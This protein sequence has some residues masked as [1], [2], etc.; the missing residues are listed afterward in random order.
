MSEKI[1]DLIETEFNYWNKHRTF[2]P[3]TLNLLFD[4]LELTKEL[5]EF[6]SLID[7]NYKHMGLLEQFIDESLL[8]WRKRL[9]NKDNKLISQLFLKLNKDIANILFGLPTDKYIILSHILYSSNINFDFKL[10]FQE[11]ISPQ[12]F[13]NQD[14]DLPDIM[15]KSLPDLLATLKSYKFYNDEFGLFEN[16]APMLF[17]MPEELQIEMIYQL[18]LAKKHN[19]HEAAVLFLLHPE[20]I[21]RQLVIKLF[22][23]SDTKLFNSSD[24]RRLIVMRNWITLD[25]KKD[26]DSLIYNLRK[27]KLAPAPYPISKILRVV[28]TNADGAGAMMAFI[29][30][31]QN[32]KRVAAGYIM[33]CNI[34]IRD[35]WMNPKCGKDH[36]SMLI[37]QTYAKDKGGIL[38]IDIDKE[39]LIKL[40][41]HFI[42]EGI[43]ANRVP[44][45]NFLQV[46]ECAA[47]KNI[48]PDPLDIDEE[49][50]ALEKIV[51]NK[52]PQMLNGEDIIDQIDN[53][54]NYS[55]AA[56]SWFMEGEKIQESCHEGLKHFSLD[57]SELLDYMIDKCC[58]EEAL[59]AWKIKILT[60]CMVL[61]QKRNDFN[62]VFLL[63]SLKQL[64]DKETNP[65]NIELIRA[66]L[67]ETV[68]VHCGCKI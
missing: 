62:W 66:I 37:E 9:D 52:N 2:S 12:L 19:A 8:S 61:S 38:Y 15:P 31:K 60:T 59:N 30:S 6:F 56:T 7:K 40:T 43:V 35:T 28:T 20:K 44:K 48:T 1:K 26:Y 39:L 29:E 24:L 25:E 46:C 33:K 50:L 51:N 42:H 41:K 23:T 5:L 47:L 34:G 3:H 11:G 27:G 65:A 32:N 63:Y 57:D 64:N 54:F 36:I 67:Y 49:I 13:N 14:S 21:M 18:L 58:T 4:E 22:N 53:W 55:D 10:S 16:L 17:Y 68:K 45:S